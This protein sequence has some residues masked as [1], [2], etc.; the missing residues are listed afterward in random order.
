MF[1]VYQ[2]GFVYQLIPAWHT[3]KGKAGYYYPPSEK[4]YHQKNHGKRLLNVIV[5]P[6]NI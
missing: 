1:V 2:D 5:K 3:T 6:K 4:V